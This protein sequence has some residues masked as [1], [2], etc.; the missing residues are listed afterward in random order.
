MNP[1]EEIDANIKDMGYVIATPRALY[2]SYYKLPDKT[3]IKA[4]VSINY[5]IPDPTSPEGYSINSNNMISAFVPKE[6]RRPEKFQ[7]YDPNELQTGIIDD[8]MD[9]EVLRENF[10]VYDL[11]NGMVLSV[12]TV[13]GQ[14]RKTKF[15]TRD[16]EPVYLI[17]TN[18]II[19]VKKK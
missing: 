2:P 6:N 11:S 16:G 7:Q 8:D 14:I 1:E 13:V 9:V 5:L 4:L 19:K 18:P 12:K 17:N 10:S 3:I 15:F